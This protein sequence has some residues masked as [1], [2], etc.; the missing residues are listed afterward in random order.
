MRTFIVS[1]ILSHASLAASLDARDGAAK[2]AFPRAFR[3]LASAKDDSSP[4]APGTAAAA[5]DDDD[6]DISDAEPHDFG[7]AE[8]II[9][10]L[11]TFSAIRRCLPGMCCHSSSETK[12]MY[13]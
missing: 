7:K 5:D 11:Q 8:I 4:S 3:I 9:E 2:V 10:D 13:G 6:D 12:G 1:S